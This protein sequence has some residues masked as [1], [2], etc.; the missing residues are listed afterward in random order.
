MVLER[1]DIDWGKLR[2]I[3]SKFKKDFGFSDGKLNWTQQIADNFVSELKSKNNNSASQV[4][5]RVK[6]P[7]VDN[8]CISDQK[9]NSVKVNPTEKRK[10]PSWMD[11]SSQGNKNVAVKKKTRF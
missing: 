5:E 9:Q 7:D 6:S 8:S 10:L 11:S 3:V 1:E 4:L 2:L